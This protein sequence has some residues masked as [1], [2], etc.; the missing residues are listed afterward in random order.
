MSKQKKCPICGEINSE[1]CN[2]NEKLFYF[3]TTSELDL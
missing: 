2:L 1:A 3:Y